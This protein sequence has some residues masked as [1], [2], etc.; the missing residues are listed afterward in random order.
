MRLQIK[1]PSEKTITLQVEPTD[2]IAN[3]KAKIQDKEKIPPDK[4][5]LNLGHLQ[6]EDDRTLSDYNI[7]EESTLQLT[8]EE[9]MGT[10][11]IKHS[12]SDTLIINNTFT[13]SFRY[14]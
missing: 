12:F 3:V 14:K 8:L 10:L 5:N 6:L 1:T 7:P 4:Q 9:N 13:F 2:T 11:S